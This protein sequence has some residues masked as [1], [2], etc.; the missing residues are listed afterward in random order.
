[1]NHLVLYR[2]KEERNIIHTI[3]RRKA[4][5]IG[6]L[7]QVIEGRAGVIAV[8]RRKG[9]RRKPLLDEPRGYWKLKEKSRIC[10]FE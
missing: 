5:W 2:V 8:T 1:L 4:N 10:I 3:K 9:R 7:K 6:L